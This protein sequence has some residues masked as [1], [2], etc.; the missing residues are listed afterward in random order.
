MYSRGS[1][2][3][4]SA[5]SRLAGLYSETIVLVSFTGSPK[6][7]GHAAILHVAQTVILSTTLHPLVNVLVQLT[8][9]NPA[10]SA[11]LLSHYFPSSLKVVWSRPPCV[12]WHLESIDGAVDKIRS[13]VGETETCRVNLVQVGEDLKL[14]L[15]RQMWEL[16]FGAV[17]GEQREPSGKIG[18]E[19]KVE[20]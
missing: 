1:H 11:F 19:F 12:Q 3:V 20:R 17:R 13:W 16:G 2:R 5:P 7:H 14:K 15:G 6:L 4:L 18:G 8:T 10:V 9:E